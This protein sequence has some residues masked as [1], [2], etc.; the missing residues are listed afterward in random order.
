M[1]LLMH[2]DRS[3]GAVAEWDSDDFCGFLL[4]PCNDILD[5]GQLE[6][7]QDMSR[8]LS[9]YWINSSHNTYLTANQVFVTIYCQRL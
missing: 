3:E 1:T 2:Q 5:P 4:S 9:Q 8:P 6:V 7:N